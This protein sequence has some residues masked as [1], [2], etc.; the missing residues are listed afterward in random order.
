MRNLLIFFILF[1]CQ[2]KEKIQNLLNSNDKTEI[3]KG[4]SYISSIED[5][6]YI[7]LLFKN[8]TDE[9]ISHNIKYNG[10]S[11]YQSKI[12]ALKRI[13]G[14]NPP[15]KITYSVD[16]TNINFYKNWAIEKGYLKVLK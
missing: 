16:T 2:S 3:M 9:R 10:I 15:N 1:S 11:V 12:A 7:P 5:T 14:I 4:C 6:I 8:I 13:S